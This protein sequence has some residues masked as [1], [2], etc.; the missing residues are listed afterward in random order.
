M[1]N[2]PRVAS[3]HG[4]QWNIDSVTWTDQALGGGKTDDLEF[5]GNVTYNLEW[6]LMRAG[7]LPGALVQVRA[8]S[9]FGSSGILNT[10]QIVPMSTVALSPTNYVDFD[11]GY[12]LALTQLTYLQMLSGK[13]GVILGKF[14]LYGDGDMNEFAGGRGRTQFQNW[15]LNYGTSTIF[16]PATTLGAGVVYLHSE[17]LIFE[18]LLVSGTACTDGG[19]FD[20]LNDKGGISINEVIYQYEAGGLPG[21][22]TGSFIY[23]FDMDFET[24]DGIL[25]VPASPGLG[26]LAE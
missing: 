15:S 11:D 26:G 22:F 8:E 18:S 7:I 1:G 12:G 25:P 3:H 9:R 6:D 16:V 4:F 17:N 13:F 21:G 20:D 5:G 23:M 10:G 2:A 14:D 19:C 24:L